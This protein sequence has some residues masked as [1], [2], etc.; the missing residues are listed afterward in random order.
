MDNTPSSTGSCAAEG[1]L[2]TPD[3]RKNEPSLR[4]AIMV[5]F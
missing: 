2:W 1:G 5:K 3:L 4:M